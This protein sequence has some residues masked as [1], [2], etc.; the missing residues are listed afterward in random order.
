MSKHAT[1]LDIIREL[2]NL[3]EDAT[4]RVY[5]R[6]SD[7]VKNNPSAT[8]GETHDKAYAIIYTEGL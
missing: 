8:E 6:F 2:S 3:N 7:W 1:I 4:G 5:K